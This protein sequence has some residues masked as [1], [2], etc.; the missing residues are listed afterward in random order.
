GLQG[1]FADGIAEHLGAHLADPPAGSFLGVVEVGQQRAEVFPVLD[2]S[3]DVGG[4]GRRRGLL[5]TG[6]LLD[7]RPMFGAFELEGGQIENLAALKINGGLS[8]EILAARTLQAAVRVNVRGR[9]AGL[10][11]ATGMAGL[12]AR[13]AAGLLAQALGFGLFGSVRGRGARTVAAVLR[14]RVPQLVQLRLKVEGIVDQALWI[15]LVPVPQLLAT[16]IGRDGGGHWPLTDRG[17]CLSPAHAR[18]YPGGADSGGFVRSFGPRRSSWPPGNRCLEI[19]PIA[20]R[21][22]AGEGG[23]RSAFASLGR[24]AGRFATGGGW[25]SAARPPRAR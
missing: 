3:F 22:P 21:S 13:F 1:R 20:R 8:G 2:G 9:V 5:A 6:A 14:G 12:A 19:G 25:P 16:L 18:H 17:K 7:L 15:G 10:E 4:K 24:S 11:G 23:G